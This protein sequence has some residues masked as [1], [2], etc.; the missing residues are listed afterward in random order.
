MAD[1]YKDVRR[2]QEA[3]RSTLDSTLKTKMLGFANETGKEAIGFKKSAGDTVYAPV[4]H[5]S[6]SF[7]DVTVEELAGTGN[8]N[9]GINE[10]GKLI[11]LEEVPV[12]WRVSSETSDFTAL[13]YTI[14]LVDT[15]SVDING[16]IPDTT[17]TVFQTRIYKTSSIN[18]PDVVV[19]T[20]SSQLVGGKTVQLIQGESEGF[21]AVSN[22]DHY[23][24]VQD[25]RG[26]IEKKL[27]QSTTIISGYEITQNGGNPNLIDIGEGIF[28][29]EICAVVPTPP[30]TSVLSDPVSVE[31]KT[32][33]VSGLIINGIATDGY[34]ILQ[35]KGDG[36]IDQTLNSVPSIESQAVSPRI[37]VIVHFGGNV[38]SAEPWW[39]ASQNAGQALNWLLNKLGILKEGITFFGAT[40]GNLQLAHDSGIISYDGA[41]GDKRPTN[42]HEQPI[43]SSD[44]VSSFILAK[45]D[46]TVNFAQTVIDPT[47]YD[48]N[49]TLT[50]LT[51][52][53]KVSIQ[54]I[55]INRNGSL[56]VQYG[57]HVWASMQDALT[58]FTEGR[59]TFV[60]WPVIT[61]VSRIGAYLIIDKACT[62]LTD[63]NTAQFIQT[64]KFEGDSGISAGSELV[65]LLKALQNGNSAGGLDIVDVGLLE[66]E[67]SLVAKGGAQLNPTG[68]NNAVV[69]D[70]QEDGAPRGR[71]RCRDWDGGT[72][73]KLNLE[74]S[75]I[76]VIAD[77]GTVTLSNT[78]VSDIN[79]AGS[80]A[81]V[82]KEYVDSALSIGSGYTAGTSF[83]L[84]DGE[85]ITIDGFFS[86][87]AA[88]SEF[89]S[90]RTSDTPSYNHWTMSSGGIV[91]QG[92]GRSELIGRTNLPEGSTTFTITRIGG[93]FKASL[94]LMLT[95]DPDFIASYNWEID[96]V[97]GSNDF[98]FNDTHT[99][100]DYTI[101]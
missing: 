55:L 71:I 39:T 24:V 73:G 56:T 26:K 34:T 5:N 38:V 77:D 27:S 3:S 40:V 6:A 74:A 17:A 96:G 25:N 1:E 22:S 94:K 4:E 13:D 30:S 66:A 65:T 83:S 45:Q 31:Y 101:R 98:S 15:S 20:P 53:D 12:G 16:T 21:F 76:D 70:Y 19:S 52:N 95:N 82:T 87:G 86:G 7:N 89:D 35:I 11:Q 67:K 18:S 78:T 2:V 59:D 36:G 33:A 10:D 80:K 9:A 75:V 91:Y 90:N 42:P 64:G 32:D 60:K 41:D 46:D 69:V 85:T 92:Q 23:D 8:R 100:A 44:P 93:K 62:D 43:P 48:V 49:G 58:A 79:T 14:H 29:Q 84:S 37:A 50:T 97:I 88:V 99:T 63:T 54:R 28:S 72:W 81:V 51:G 57:Q 68:L 61:E 47:Q